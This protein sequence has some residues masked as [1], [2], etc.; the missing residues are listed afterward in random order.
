MDV[1]ERN[2]LANTILLKL[3][4]Y[5]IKSGAHKKHIPSEFGG[6]DQPTLLGYLADEIIDDL[7]DNDE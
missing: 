2:E 1:K 3:A 4:R 5:I 6:Y 7:G